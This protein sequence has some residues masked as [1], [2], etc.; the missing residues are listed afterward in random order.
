MQ[1]NYRWPLKV[2]NF[3]LHLRS[4]SI[5]GRTLFLVRKE[6]YKVW[7]LFLKIIRFRENLWNFHK[8]QDHLF[9]LFHKLV[10]KIY[11]KKE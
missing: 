6:D 9:P 10:I 11:K 3:N 1:R 2:K 7:G 8:C 5:Q 4:I